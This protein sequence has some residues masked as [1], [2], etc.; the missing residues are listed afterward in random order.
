METN[1]VGMTFSEYFTQVENLSLQSG[2]RQGLA[3]SMRQDIEE[4]F[5]CEDSVEEA[6]NNI[7]VVVY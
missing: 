4:A 7:F 5:L 1:K 3:V 6:F 2:F